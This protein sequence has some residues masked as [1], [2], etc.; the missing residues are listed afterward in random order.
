MSSLNIYQRSVVEFLKYHFY[1][2]LPAIPG[3]ASVKSRYHL[4]KNLHV[5]THKVQSHVLVNDEKKVVMGM[6]RTETIPT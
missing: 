1:V 4:P 6:V 3:L 5:V 2:F